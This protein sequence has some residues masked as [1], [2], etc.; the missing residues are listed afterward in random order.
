MP[1]IYFQAFAAVDDDNTGETSVSSLSRV[2]RTSALPASTIDKVRRPCPHPRIVTN[3]QVCPQ[4]VSLVS[5]RPRVSRVEFYV[6]LAL[7]ALVQGGKGASAAA[8]ALLYANT[9]PV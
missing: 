4:I 7:A 9:D 2:L 8:L 3:R 5:S 1:P 6:A